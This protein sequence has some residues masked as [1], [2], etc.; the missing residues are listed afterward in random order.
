M[1]FVP[2][3][4]SVWWLPELSRPREEVFTWAWLSDRLLSPPSEDL[5]SRP[6]TG[7]HSSP[8]VSQTVEEMG[9]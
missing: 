8:L 3:G 5:R 4:P 1:P 7:A 2:E 9:L 6:T